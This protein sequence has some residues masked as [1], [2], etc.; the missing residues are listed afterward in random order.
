MTEFEM[1]LNKRNWEREQEYR[2]HKSKKGTTSDKV[3]GQML[4]DDLWIFKV[5]LNAYVRY[6]DRLIEEN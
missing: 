3:I 1:Y 4:S 6:M 2:V 5:R